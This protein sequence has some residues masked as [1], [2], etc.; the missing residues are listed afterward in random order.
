MIDI[1]GLAKVII[2]VILC[3]YRVL[4]SIIIDLGLLFIS[5]F[6]SL[7]YYFLK[8]KKKLFIVFYQKTDSQIERQKSIIEAYLKA[9]VNC[10]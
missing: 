2:N 7:L 3:H 9:F 5:K 1:L 10:K 8:I 6:G 4:K